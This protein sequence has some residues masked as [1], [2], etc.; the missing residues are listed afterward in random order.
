MSGLRATHYITSCT[1]LDASGTYQPY[2]QGASAKQTMLRVSSQQLLLVDNSKFERTALHKYAELDE[3]SHIFVQN[4]LPEEFR[5][6]LSRVEER[7]RVVD[8]S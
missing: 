7:V 4:D 3:F 1:A 6:Q 5:A 2:S 8:V